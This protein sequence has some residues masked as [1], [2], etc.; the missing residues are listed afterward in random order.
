MT[1]ILTFAKNKKII[2]NLAKFRFLQ[3][4]H[5]NSKLIQ[6]I[7]CKGFFQSNMKK[8]QAAKNGVMIIFEYDID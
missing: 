7:H 2:E 3:P 1:D 4:N 6:L 8:I 5:Y